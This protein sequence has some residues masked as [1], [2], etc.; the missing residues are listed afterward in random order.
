MPAP[1]PGGSGAR[2]TW[3]LALPSAVEAV[4]RARRGVVTQLRDWGC[5]PLCDAAALVVSELVTNAV[6]HARTP[7]ELS[8]EQVRNG[9]RVTV[10]DLAD[11]LPAMGAPMSLASNGRGLVLLEALAQSW[12]VDTHAGGGKTVWA[13]LT[14]DSV[15]R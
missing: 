14:E 8:L 9:V 13:L 1:L 12:G 2:M 6:L 10:R 5:E 3:S 7:I 4:P 11:G 15:A